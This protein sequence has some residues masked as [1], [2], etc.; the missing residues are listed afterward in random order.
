[1]SKAMQIIKK[2]ESKII[3]Q[4]IN[5]TCTIN[6]CVKLSKFNSFKTQLESIENAI[7]KE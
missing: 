7:I 3:S 1:M 6:V 5:T 2:T 4:E